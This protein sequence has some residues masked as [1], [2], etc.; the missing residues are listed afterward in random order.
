MSERGGLGHGAPKRF[1]LTPW[2]F[3]TATDVLAIGT[4]ARCFSGPGELALALPVCVAVHLFA[5]G[6]RR[7]A[8]RRALRSS[9]SAAARSRTLGPFGWVLAIAVGLLVPLVALDGHTFS[10]ALPLSRTWHAVD[11]QLTFA[12]SIFSN[13]LAPVVEAPGLVIATAWA[14]GAVALASEVLYADVG[15]PAILALV[16]AFDVVVFT[17]TLGTSTGR[18]VE[19]ALM[20]GLA[21]AFLLTSQADR[22]GNRVVV[23]ARTDAGPTDAGRSTPSALKRRALPGVAV[24]A[25]LA[26]GVIGPVLPGATSAPLIAWHGL[27]ARSGSSGSNAG[28]GTGGPNKILVSDFVEVAEQ[29]VSDSDALLFTVHS[30]VRTR[31]TLLTLDRF[32]G[33]SWSRIVDGAPGQS[34]AVPQFH[35]QLAALEKDP[36]A[37]TNVPGGGQQVE[38]VIDIAGLGGSWL[39]TPGKTQAVDGDGNVSELGLG[40][41]L[42]ASAPLTSDLTYAVRADLPQTPTASSPALVQPGIESQDLQLPDGVPANVVA[43]AK[44]LVVGAT[45][46][47]EEAEQI[48]DYFLSGHGFV[49]QLPTIVGGAVANSS[50]NYTAL[51]AFLFHHK[52]GYCQ[53][54]ATSFAVLARLDGLPTRIAVG[55]LPGKETGPD[56][57]VVSGSQVHAWPEVY[58]TGYGW[59]TFEPT[60][61]APGPTGTQPTPTTLKGGGPTKPTATTPRPGHNFK[62]SAAGG[63]PAKPSHSHHRTQRAAN[64]VGTS[65]VTDIV[66]GF[67]GLGIAWA[68]AVPLWRFAR[69]RRDRRNDRLATLAAWR[70]ANWVLAAASA[71]RRRSE[72]H[73][74]FAARVR[75]LGLLGQE[76]DEA[77][78]RLA[79]RMDRALYAPDRGDSA[80]RADASAA[81][82]DSAL[83][84]RSARRRIPWWQ[85]LSLIVDPRDL[86]GPT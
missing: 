19:L 32:N 61:G 27:A 50:D 60:P 37:P 15:L 5:G 24:V 47:F 65:G 55:F 78:E 54:Y 28:A 36:P 17:G 67:I 86:L 51:E 56:T 57:Y 80:R 11:G 7:L 21:I 73:L 4:L 44:S 2:I 41:P 52:V 59:V 23:M 13:K 6:G 71:H 34:L 10:Y 70:S 40:G 33:N 38:Q 39:P 29:E 85:Q 81:W 72:T 83:V 25:A 76:G 63:N 1:G 68:V 58:L 8:T 74:E 14:A 18:A 35:T 79:H 30:S 12:W 16:P 43:L 3:L 64:Q 69:R 42:V 22:Q 20:A 77:L 26:A 45:T 48:Q 66:L 53:Q 49:Y 31:E 9:P 84:R 46:P 75:N 82:S 62:P